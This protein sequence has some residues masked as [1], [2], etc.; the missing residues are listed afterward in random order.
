MRWACSPSPKSSVIKTTMSPTSNRNRVDIEAQMRTPLLANTPSN[1]MTTQR[2]PAPFDLDDPLT[3]C[4]RE[5]LGISFIT[6]SIYWA[7]QLPITQSAICSLTTSTPAYIS[8]IFT[9]FGIP[10]LYGIVVATC[11]RHCVLKCRMYIFGAEVKAYTMICCSY[12]LLMGLVFAVA[13]LQ[14]DTNVC[15]SSEE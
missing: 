4:I 6:M 3:I 10:T 13:I 8:G 2:V 14:W 1:S 15:W 9:T 12:V 5:T 7:A 11:V